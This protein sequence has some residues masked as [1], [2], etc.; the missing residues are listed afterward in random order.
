MA[1]S[2]S[3]GRADGGVDDEQLRGWD[4][5]RRLD[6]E[7]AARIPFAFRYCVEQM[8]EEMIFGDDD[9]FVVVEDRAGLAEGPLIVVLLDSASDV[10]VERR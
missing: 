7:G 4:R 3:S 6:L 8:T 1:R 10:E 5:V 2:T 9:G